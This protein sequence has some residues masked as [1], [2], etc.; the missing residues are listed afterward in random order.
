MAAMAIFD[1]LRHWR[2][3]PGGVCDED[4]FFVLR[5]QAP[6]VAAAKYAESKPIS[7]AL[8]CFARISRPRHAC[9]ALIG[10]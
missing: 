6:P 9:Q 5:E 4:S 10:Q 2:D 7:A 1:V 3:I 8:A